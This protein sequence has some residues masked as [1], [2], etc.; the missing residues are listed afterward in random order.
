MKDTVVYRLF[1]KVVPVIFQWISVL[2]YSTCRINIHGQEHRDQIDAHDGPAIGSFWHYSILFSMFFLRKIG[3]VAMVSASKDGEIVSNIVKKMGY[4][5]VRGS[6]SRGGIKA[7]KGL[8]RHIR[9]GKNAAIVADGSL[10]P[11]R[12]VQAG[13]I[14]LAS[15]TG[16]PILPFLWSCN[17][18]KRFASWDGTSLPMPFSKIEFF[19]GEPL[20]VPPK[21]K[22]DGIEEYRLILEN[23]LNDLYT[24][25]WGL[26]G[27]ITH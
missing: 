21:I 26:Q 18:Y 9:Q 3:G 7:M 10:G 22:S 8:M 24:E 15:R 27:K 6:R 14:M 19:Y 4:E 11:P 1:L 16:A 20:D 23:R 12:V 2:L 17:N 5:T 25:A 13:C